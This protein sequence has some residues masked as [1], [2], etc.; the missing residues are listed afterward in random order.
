[1]FSVRGQNGNFDSK[2]YDK[3]ENSYKKAFCFCVAVG[4]ACFFSR[5]MGD[6]SKISPMYFSKN[7]LKISNFAFLFASCVQKIFLKNLTNRKKYA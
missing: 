6:F 1:M 7:T 3:N 5:E 2:I 4:C